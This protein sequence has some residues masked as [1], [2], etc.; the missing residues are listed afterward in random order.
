[1]KKVCLEKDGKVE[2]VNEDF[3]TFLKGK[4]SELVSL[5]K[6]IEKKEPKEVILLIH[7]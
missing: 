3:L 6:L 4:D 1:L 2:K 7:Q 5:E